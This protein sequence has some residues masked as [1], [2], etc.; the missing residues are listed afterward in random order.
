MILPILILA[1]VTLERLGELVLAQRNTRRLM[2]QGAREVGARHYPLI[3][4]LHG[5]WL[6]GLWLLAW[7]RPADLLWLAIF[8]ILQAARVWVI[9]SLG[10]RWTTRIVVLP[11]APLVSRGP[12]RL[13]RHPNY[14]VVAGEIAV[15]PLVFHLYVYAAVFFLLNAAVLA[16]RIRVEERALRLTA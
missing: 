13:F 12:Y 10:G 15:L 9:A 5:A 6:A 11:Q 7:D 4:L 3:V 2:T 8:L 1:A 16:Q 14:M